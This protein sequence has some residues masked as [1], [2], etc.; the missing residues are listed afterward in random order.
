VNLIPH[1]VVQDGRKA[2]EFYQAAFGA[3][4]GNVNLTPD[5]EKV[6]HAELSFGGALVFLCDEFDNM[7]CAKSP[8]TLGGSPVTLTLA[9]DDADAVFNRAVQ[10]GAK[11]IMP[12]ADQFWGGRY[13]QV[14]D[15]FGHVWAVNQFVREVSKDDIQQATNEIFA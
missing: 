7:G 5:G 2:L 1:L 9:V 10:A 14:Q 8:A 3:E 4:L 6:F 13:G 15:P 12:V 11:G